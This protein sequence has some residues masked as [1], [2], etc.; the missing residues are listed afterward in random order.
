MA[1][2]VRIR[3]YPTREYLGF[4]FAYL[5]E[6]EPPAFPRYPDYEKGEIWTEKY[7]RPCNFFNNL[8]NDPVHIP[9]AHRESEIFQHRPIEVPTTVRAEE[10]E[11][12]IT[13]YT[14][15]PGDRLRTTQFGW[16]NI[17]TFKSPERDH[18][19]WRVPIE[20]ELHAS[21]QLDVM[22]ITEGERGQVYK[23]RH[24][25]RTGK[26]GRSYKELSEAILRGDLRIQDIEGDDKANMIWIQDYVTQ[27]GLGTFADRV[28]ERLIRSDAGV[29][30]YRKIWER[31]V[32]ALAANKAPKQ[33]TRSDR[34]IK[35][36]SYHVS[37]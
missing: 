3:S 20:D 25:V 37:E 30:L 18:L 14:T 34:L 24:A 9:F 5:G 19:V 6:G 17:R 33:W 29:L 15:Y 12:G 1:K 21:F 31:E 35:A 23:Q 7:E 8:E 26:L 22:H 13:L 32:S 36:Y 16:P 2:T 10:S 28:N 11:W 4:I 27:V